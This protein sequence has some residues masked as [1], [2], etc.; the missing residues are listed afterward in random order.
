MSFYKELDNLS[1]EELIEKFDSKITSNKENAYLYYPEVAYLIRRKGMN[2]IEFLKNN[3]KNRSAIKVGA[4]LLGLTYPKC[5]D[6]YLKQQLLC[7]LGDKRS[8]VVQ[9]AVK[10]LEALEVKN[11]FEYV[12]PLLSHHSPYV[13]ANTLSFISKL[14]PEVALPFLINSI[15]HKHYIVRETTADEMGELYQ[16]EAIPYLEKLLADPHHDVREAAKTAIA[17]INGTFLD[18]LKENNK[19]SYYT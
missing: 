6:E 8:F 14:Y 15:S 3:L 17:F 18:F 2:G 12:L 1:L 11:A 10:G 4:A 5:E 16:K 7:Y 13:V 19:N 9:C